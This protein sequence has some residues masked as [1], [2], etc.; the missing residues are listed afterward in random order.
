MKMNK[1]LSIATSNLFSTPWAMRQSSLDLTIVNILKA[2]RGGELTIEYK[3]D[4]EYEVVN[5]KAVIDVH[6]IFYNKLML[7]VNW[8]YVILNLEN[9]LLAAVDDYS[10]E[11]VI[12]KVES[13][14]GIIFG[15]SEIH[16]LIKELNTIKPINAYVN[17]IACSALYWVPS[18]CENIYSYTQSC[19]GSIGVYQMHVDYSKLMED[20]GVKVE[21]IQAGKYKTAGNPYEPLSEEGRKYLQEGIN[22]AYGD[23]T[24]EVAVARGLDLNKI[25]DWADGKDF[26]TKEALELGLIDE[27]KTWQDV[28]GNNISN[29][30]QTRRGSMAIGEKKIS[31]LNAEDLQKSNPALYSAILSEGRIEG[32]NAAVEKSNA[33]ISK[34]EAENASLT[35]QVNQYKEAE[36]VAEDQKKIRNFAKSLNLAEEGETLIS[37]NK[38]VVEAFETLANAASKAK[39]DGQANFAA[40]APKI[41]GNGSDNMAD[42]TPKTDVEAVNFCAKKYNLSKRQAWKKARAEFSSLFGNVKNNEEESE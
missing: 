28:L 9:S 42:D 30:S 26:E 35:A 4:I 5:G 27:I 38:S 15:V 3:N 12:L 6:G 23:F 31:E 16:N 40:G 11:E 33:T 2:E 34:L 17:G 13:P 18:A 32:N 8:G 22:Q 7:D 21:Y 20:F 10:V 1:K 29:S 41:A 39:A 24:K 25:S 19:I 36:K 37:E 14:G